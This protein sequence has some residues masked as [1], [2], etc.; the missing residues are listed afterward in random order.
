MSYL[1]PTDP[2][3]FLDFPKKRKIPKDKKVCPQCFGHGGWNLKISAYPLFKQRNT[4]ANRHKFSHFRAG[5]NCCNGWG[6]VDLSLDHIH[7]W[8]FSRQLGNCYKEYKC[9]VC[10]KIDKVD[11]SD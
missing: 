2:D 3:A 7:D 9:S 5:C 8:K 10:G 4:A 1:K 11:S 6:Y